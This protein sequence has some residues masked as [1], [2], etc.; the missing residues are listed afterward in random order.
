MAEQPAFLQ[1][2][3]LAVTTH[4]T[5]LHGSFPLW[6]LKSTR[7]LAQSYPITYRWPLYE[8]SFVHAGVWSLVSHQ[9]VL[10]WHF[11]RSNVLF[12]VPGRLLRF[13]LQH[14]HSSTF[15]PCQ[16]TSLDHA[17]HSVSGPR[18]SVG[19]DDLEHTARQSLR[20]VAQ[21]QWL[22]ECYR[23]NCSPDILV[24]SATEMLHDIALYKFTTDIDIKC[25]TIHSVNGTTSFT[26]TWEMR[27]KHVRTL[28][29]TCFVSY[30]HLTR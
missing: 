17:A 21:C 24:F 18:I 3:E 6:R 19:A 23:Q 14:R 27:Q 12:K 7:W 5:Q 11:N 30:I 16:S 13:G 29:P 20:P 25:Q 4:S 28:M 15:T 26:A 22:G 10:T 2:D 1:V 8:W 9:S